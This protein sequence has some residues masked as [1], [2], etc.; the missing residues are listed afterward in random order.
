MAFGGEVHHPIRLEAAEERGH[1]AGVTDVRV[2]ELVVGVAGQIV[3][4]VPV[5]GVGQRIHIEDAM[6]RGR[7][8]ETDEIAADEAGAAGD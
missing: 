5:A 8:Q 6:G 4:R 3:E 1:G 7:E 2:R